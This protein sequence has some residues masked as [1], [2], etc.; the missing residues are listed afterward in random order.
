MGILSK[1]FPMYPSPQAY[2]MNCGFNC[3]AK[4]HLCN[5]SDW[6]NMGMDAEWRGTCGNQRVGSPFHTG[7]QIPLL[8]IPG[9]CKDSIYPDSLHC[10]HLGWGVDMAASG[11]VLLCKHQCFNG[12][13]LD[14]KLAEAYRHYTSWVSCNK[15]TTGIDWWSKQ[16][17]DM[18]SILD[19]T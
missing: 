1:Y 6:H 16:K 18:T 7:C 4:C 12:R 3:V 13:S 15:K 11:I 9:M 8:K 17:L 14:A 5:S 19:L 2:H 10:F